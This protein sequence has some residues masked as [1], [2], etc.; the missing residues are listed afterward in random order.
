M[1]PSPD[2]GLLSPGR[3]WALALAY[4][5][6]VHLTSSFAPGPTGFIPLAGVDKLVH[7]CEFGALALV[8]WRPVRDA[9]PR[10]PELRVAA[11]LFL[12]VTVNGVLD[13]FH[14]SFVPGRHASWADA[15]ADALGAG[16]AIFWLLHREKTRV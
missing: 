15:A 4:L 1:S 16:A 7:L 11:V 3:R 12:F 8:F 5:G 2:A 6:L 10:H 14:Q 9:A 13:E